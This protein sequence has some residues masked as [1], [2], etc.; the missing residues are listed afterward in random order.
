MEVLAWLW[1]ALVTIVGVVWSLVW[2][3]I[4]GWVS[5]L[6]QIALLVGAIYVL[7]YGWRRAP[8]EFWQSTRSLGGFFWNWLRVRDPA[9]A[10][11]VEVREVVRVIRA[12]EFG[13]VNLSTLLSLLVFGGLLLISRV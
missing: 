3:L 1:W 8:I 13:D 6:L 7:K 2:F 10:P 5:T 4:R 12:K 9:A 11:R